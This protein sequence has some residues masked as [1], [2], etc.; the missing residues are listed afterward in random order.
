MTMF[1]FLSAFLAGSWAAA[2]AATVEEAGRIWVVAA[3]HPQADDEGAATSEQPFRTIS[4]AAELAEPGDII[5]VHAGVYRERVAPAR[6]GEPGRRIVYE[7]VPGEKVVVT[8]ADVWDPAWEPDPAQPTLVSAALG[9]EQ[10]GYFD[11]FAEPYL[12]REGRSL[13][14]VAVAG[15]LLDEMPTRGTMRARRGTWWLDRA[16]RRVHLHLPAGVLMAQNPI[17]EVTVRDRLFAPHQRGLGYI[18]VRGFTFD[19]AANQF[20]LRFWFPREVGNN[21]PQTGAVGTRSGHH[22]IIENNVVRHAASIGIDIGDEGGW[23]PEGD[24]SKPTYLGRHLIRGNH[25]HDCGSTGIMGLGAHET[26]IID[27][28]IERINLVGNTAPECGGIKVHD[29]VDGEIRGNLV[30][31]NDCSGIWLDNAYAGSRVTQNLVLNNEDMGIFIELGFGPV[32]VDHN[33]VGYTRGAGIYAHDASGITLAHN[34]LFS[35]AHFGVYAH[36]ISAREFKLPD[37]SRRPVESSAIRVLNNVFIDNFRGDISLPPEAPRSTGNFS[38]HNL[39][40]TGT[41][42]WWEG[43]PFL[44]F[45]LN[46]NSDHATDALPP[47]VEVMD[48]SLETWREHT[49]WDLHS[50]TDRIKSKRPPSFLKGAGPDP[51]AHLAAR[52]LHFDMLEPELLAAIQAPRVPGTDYDYLGQPLGYG[53]VNPGPWRD[54]AGKVLPLPLWPRPATTESQK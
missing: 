5:R 41:R 37:D 17:V 27:N 2:A 46:T 29:F 14:Q 30:R 52:A 12:R 9:H 3:E 43:E 31:D 21:H 42:A 7:A 11:Q 50:A 36:V 54:L 47:G 51:A 19:R 48:M 20:P 4:R 49:G 10:P 18:T 53:K 22:W 39:F 24:Q 15:R 32:L 13:G 8:G 1:R 35:N 40:L 23:D 6:G 28:V 44:S 33:I 45:R 34:L 16:E 26:H 38:D 25:I